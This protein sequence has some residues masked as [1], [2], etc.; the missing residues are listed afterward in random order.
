[1]KIFQIALRLSFLFNCSL[2]VSC[3]HSNSIIIKG[4]I[5]GLDA[6]MVYLHNNYPV[7]S[8]PIDSA[9]VSNHKFVFV[10]NPDT[11][12]QQNLVFI[13]YKDKDGKRKSLSVV[14]PYNPRSHYQSFIMETGITTLNGTVSK[15][16]EIKLAAGKQNEFYF[17]NPDLPFLMISRD[18]AIRQAKAE[19]IQKLIHANPDA[20]WM[21]FAFENL[22]FQFSKKQLNELYDEFSD[23]IKQ[24]NEGKELKK[25]INLIPENENNF[26]DNILVDAMNTSIKLIDTTKKLNMVVFWASWCGPCR[27]EIP[28]I[29]RI[30]IK[31]DGKN[32]RIV[33]VTT[34]EEKGKWLSAV[35]EE[36]MPWQQL[37][38]PAEKK[39][40][41]IAQYNLYHVPQIYFVN[42]KNM[43]V[44]KVRGFEEENETKIQSFIDQYLA[45]N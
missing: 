22:K 34:D 40:K 33:S 38:I 4:D 35:K 7:G 8:P 2:V 19:S 39:Q 11:T 28:S 10:F 21:K 18:S 30:A 20:Y 24:T 13:A 6:K 44:K 16:D 9:K 31:Q 23:N 27:M 45:K 5:Y 43:V 1:M 29:K 25:F 42:N 37:F 12:F 15:F 32:F 17:K 14:N 3:K 41:A 36:N 26:S